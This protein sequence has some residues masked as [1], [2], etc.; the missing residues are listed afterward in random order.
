MKTP[1]VARRGF[2]SQQQAYWAGEALPSES[3]GAGAG[4][5]GAGADGAD[6]SGDC[7]GPVRFGCTVADGIVTL[8]AALF[9]TS[10][11]GWLD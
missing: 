10:D 11:V 8:E 1:A 3:E 2:H 5:A 7:E 6:A 9:A 4:C